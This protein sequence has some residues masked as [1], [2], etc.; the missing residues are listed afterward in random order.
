MALVPMNWQHSWRSL[1][2]E[3]SERKK[4]QLSVSLFSSKLESANKTFAVS[5]LFP[6]T[7]WFPFPCSAWHSFEKSKPDCIFLPSLLTGTMRRERERRFSASNGMED[8]VNGFVWTNE[9]ASGNLFVPSRP[10]DILKFK[11]YG[12][13]ECTRWRTCKCSKKLR[14]V[15]RSRHE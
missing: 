14:N 10:K 12:I 11:V 2:N 8:V 9:R 15:S 6:S 13:C 5:P 3:K 7:A 1:R 4:K